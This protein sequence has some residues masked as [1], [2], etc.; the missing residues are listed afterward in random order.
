MP[1][2]NV[3]TLNKIHKP[4]CHP[5]N[6]KFLVGFFIVL[7]VVLSLQFYKTTTDKGIK[8]SFQITWCHWDDYLMV[9]EKS[10]EL[11]VVLKFQVQLYLEWMRKIRGVQYIASLSFQWKWFFKGLF[12]SS[13]FTYTNCSVSFISLSTA[14]FNPTW[15][16]LLL[17]SCGYSQKFWCL[18]FA[19]LRQPH[20]YIPLIVISIF[21]TPSSC[22]P[23]F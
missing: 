18:I 20:S 5:S 23:A 17:N 6:H 4:S 11:S 8:K 16:V 1:G 9:S 3:C 2:K 19:C 15:T 14:H 22:F 21:Q 13:S 12:I 7:L 10:R